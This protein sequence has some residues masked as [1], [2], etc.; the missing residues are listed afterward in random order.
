M[1]LE[2]FEQENDVNRIAFLSEYSDWCLEKG[3]EE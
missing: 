3:V 2:S 1:P